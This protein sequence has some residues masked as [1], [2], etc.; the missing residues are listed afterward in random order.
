MSGS[1]RRRATSFAQARVRRSDLFRRLLGP[2][3]QLAELPTGLPDDWVRWSEVV[4]AKQ[5]LARLV[6]DGVLEIDAGEGGRVGAEAAGYFASSW[7]LPP[8]RTE[9]ARHSL[10]AVRLA[11]EVAPGAVGRVSRWLYAF[12]QTPPALA[13]V[14]SGRIRDSLLCHPDRI[15][16]ETEYSCSVGG[17]WEVWNRESNRWSQ[18][19]APRY[20]LYVSAAQR[21][22][23]KVVRRTA[24]L[25][26][27]EPAPAFKLS[28]NRGLATRPDKL[29]IYFHSGADRENWA[30]RLSE[31]LSGCRGQGVPFTLQIGSGTILSGAVDPVGV[32]ASKPESWRSWCTDRIAWAL[33]VAHSCSPDRRVLPPW[34]FALFRLSLDRVDVSRWAGCHEPDAEGR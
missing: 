12:G 22:L 27:E 23:D 34:E 9:I 17:E 15:K 13:D 4:V 32:G 28:S 21:D 3:D 1:R 29:I 2:E 20:K 19:A 5:D 30:S 31:R 24:A 16:L 11:E 26:L 8:P 10:T 6:L 25:L 7:S 14:R 18:D 33:A